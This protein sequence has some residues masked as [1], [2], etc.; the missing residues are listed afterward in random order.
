MVGKGRMVVPRCGCHIE[1][2]KILKTIASQSKLPHG[3]ARKKTGKKNM[4][5]EEGKK[6]EKGAMPE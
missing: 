5:L 3:H 4:V 1:G 2:K 6:K